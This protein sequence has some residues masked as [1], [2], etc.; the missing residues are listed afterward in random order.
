[1]NA[2]MLFDSKGRAG[3]PGLLTCSSRATATEGPAD[4]A[5]ERGRPAPTGGA[6]PAEHEMP[7]PTE[8]IPA[9]AKRERAPARSRPGDRNENP[10]AVS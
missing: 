3:V 5:V 4:H 10:Y 7:E 1:M 2:V 8:V 9:A 6:R